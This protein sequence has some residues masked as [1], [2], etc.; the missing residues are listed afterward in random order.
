MALKLELE[1]Q[2]LQSQLTVKN[3]VAHVGQ[4]H[5][6]QHP[7]HGPGGSS[8]HYPAWMM[9]PPAPDQL[10]KM[11]E[12]KQYNWC[13]KCRHGKG[14]W[15]LCHTTNTHV[16]GYRRQPK[17]PSTQDHG[18]DANWLK[19]ETNQPKILYT[20]AA[21]QRTSPLSLR[22]NCRWQITYS[23]LLQR[24]EHSITTLMDKFLLSVSLFSSKALCCLNNGWSPTYHELP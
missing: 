20:L 8:Y 4:L 2:H 24:P 9:D 23:Q 18:R 5:Q 10:A 19:H 3:L 6:K 11:H 1:W 21:S 12:N 15:V 16:N 17:W 13:S 22:L 7:G 14:L